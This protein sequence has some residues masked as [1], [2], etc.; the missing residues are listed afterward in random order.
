M[1]RRNRRLREVPMLNTA[2]LP[3][4]IF[5]VLFFFMIVTHMRT[6]TSK[7]QYALPQGTELKR[8]VKK[9]AVTY[10]Y[11]GRAM[12]ETTRE[13]SA[14]KVQLNNRVGTI[15]EVASFVA[16]EKKRMNP[17]DQ[18]K[19]TVSIKAD[20]STPMYVIN[21]VKRAVRAGGATRINYSAERESDKLKQK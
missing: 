4:L 7:V 12:P 9:S 18:V 13:M 20:R 8:L 2:S 1:I 3:D 5:T 6:T 16:N 17:D 11:I 19:M 14:Y 15:G 21:A 10:I